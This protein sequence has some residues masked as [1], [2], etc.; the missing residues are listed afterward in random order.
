[1]ANARAVV[2]LNSGGTG[3]ASVDMNAQTPIELVPGQTYYIRVYVYNA[4]DPNAS[5]GFDDFAPTFTITEMNDHG[6]FNAGDPP[7]PVDPAI[8][9]GVH[10]WAEGDITALTIVTGNIRD[11]NNEIVRVDGHDYLLGT[12]ETHTAVAGSTL[13][14]VAY[15]A[16]TGTFTITN[17]AGGAMP[18][19]DLQTLISSITYTDNQAAPLPGTRTLT[20]T[21]TDAAGQT[22]SAAVSSI[23]VGNPTIAVDDTATGLEDTSTTIDVLSTDS[24]TDGFALSVTAINGQTLEV[25]SSVA[26]ANGLVML[27]ADGTL[28]FTPQADF[29][30][31]ATFAYTVSDVNGASAVAN[32]T[33]NVAPVADIADDKASTQEDHSVTINVLGNDTFE[34]PLT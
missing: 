28:T 26:V 20:F 15:D 34:A 8:A 9:N 6:T 24:N 17:N 33:I 3:N 13:F 30:G 16:T 23:T 12:N 10:D 25:G 22:S 19:A 31:P 21:V 2:P 7:V 32:V 4:A 1:F 27:N 18:A 11:G 29:N 5:V 14:D